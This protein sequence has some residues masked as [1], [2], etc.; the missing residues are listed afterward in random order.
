MKTDVI[1]AGVDPVATNTVGARVM[2]I[3]PA[4]VKHLRHCADRGLGEL[5]AERIE[6]VGAPIAKVRKQYDQPWGFG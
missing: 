6:V 5:R 1:I 2:G 3:D 4:K